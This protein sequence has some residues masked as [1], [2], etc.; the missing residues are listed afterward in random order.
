CTL[1][2]STTTIDHAVSAQRHAAIT[3]Q[4]A[5]TSAGAGLPASALAD[6]RATPGV[7][8]AVALTPTTLGPSLGASDD[9]IPAQI[10]AGGQGGGLQ[11]GVIA[12]SLAGL[13]GQTIALGRHRAGAAHAHVGDRVAIMLGDGTRT[14][15]TVVAI[16]KRDLAFGDALLAPELAAGHETSPLL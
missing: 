1:L 13:H 16:Y 6:V 2:F 15:A 8:S 14:H 7:R 11:L 10:L 3:G 5:I 9:T 4:L 12:G